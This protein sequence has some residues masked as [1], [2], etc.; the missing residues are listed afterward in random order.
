MVKYFRILL[1]LAIVCLSACQEG[2]EAGKLLGQW[3]LEDSD[4]KY[5]SFSGSV[6]LFRLTGKAEIYGNFKHVGD[7]LFVQCFSIEGYRNDTVIVED[8]FGLKPFND[9]R[10]KIETLDHETLVLSKDNKF[11]TFDKY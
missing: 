10:V 6:S 3:R 4:D 5:V 8:M 1:F 2:G 9:I 7:S 11:W